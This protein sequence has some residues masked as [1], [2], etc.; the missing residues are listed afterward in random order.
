MRPSEDYSMTA[1]IRIPSDVF[2]EEEPEET[3]EEAF[4]RLTDERNPAVRKLLLSDRFDYLVRT[5]VIRTP[6]SD[7][8][9]SGYRFSHPTAVRMAEPL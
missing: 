8:D 2:G 6:Y 5:G 9:P 4:V 7:S 1:G 3:E